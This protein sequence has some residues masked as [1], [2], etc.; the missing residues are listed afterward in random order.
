MCKIH[1]KNIKKIFKSL[2]TMVVVKRILISRTCKK[3]Y[4]IIQRTNRFQGEGEGLNPV[5]NSPSKDKVLQ[6]ITTRGI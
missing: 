5:V 3:N 4:L 6:I 1:G 2:P